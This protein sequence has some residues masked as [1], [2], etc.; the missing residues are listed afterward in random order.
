M[1]TALSQTP[2]TPVTSP[3]TAGFTLVEMMIAIVGGLIAISSV[4]AVSGALNRQFFEQQRIAT[5]QGAAQIALEEIRHDIMRAGLFGSPNASLEKGT[6]STVSAVK[7]KSCDPTPMEL[8]KLG[9]GTMPVTA[10]QYYYDV[11]TSVVDPGG[12]NGTR[13]DRLRIV[14]N[15]MTSDRYVIEEYDADGTAGRIYVRLEEESQAFRRSFLYGYAS[16]GLPIPFRTGTNDTQFNALIGAFNPRAIVHI[17]TP[18]GNHFFRRVLRGPVFTAGLVTGH[19]ELADPLPV[20]TACLPGVARGSTIAPLTWLEYLVASPDGAEVPG[21]FMEFQGIWYLPTITEDPLL[22][23]PEASELEETNAVLVSRQ[24][25]PDT[26]APVLFT[27]RVLA[28]WVADFRIS[29]L[30]DTN[31]GTALPPNLELRDHTTSPTA[32]EVINGNPTP[33]PEQ[34]RVVIVDLALRNPV[35]DPSLPFVSADGGALTRYEV[36]STQKGSSR[37]RHAHIEIPMRNLAGRNL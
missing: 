21:A 29:F 37:V 20:K 34:V 7:G 17:E 33:A 24:L 23:P 14:G 3:G 13:A 22:P 11:D 16:T 8:D 10:F 6:S 28:E 5:T 4:Y 32:E 18:E 35:E 2:R 15:T 26:G 9:T 36:D 27:T 1:D 31:S 12:F 19:L 30:I 25:A